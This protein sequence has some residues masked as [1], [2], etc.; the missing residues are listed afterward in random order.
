MADH[1]CRRV[2]EKCEALLKR[3]V[4][5]SLGIVRVGGRGND[6]A[7]ER[8]AVK[9][10]QSLSIFVKRFL[11]EENATGKELQRVLEEINADPDIHGCLVLRPLPPHLNE[12]E[13]SRILNP[14][15]DVDVITTASMGRMVTKTGNDFAP[16]TAAAC[17]ELLQYY[18]IPLQ[19][20]RVTVVG[21][22][23]NVGLSIA[24]LLLNEEAT[25]SICHIYTPPPE[26]IRL[27]SEAD[28]II[29]A[30]GRAGL[31]GA[32]HVRP[33]QIVID[34]GVNTTENGMIRGDTDF[35]S[36]EPIVKA[37][38][39][40][41]GGIGAITSCIL[42]EHVADAAIRQTGRPIIRRPPQSWRPPGR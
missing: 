9:R 26:V 29:S 25:V 4:V 7:Y 14:E 28:I 42:M 39:P 3:G 16:C 37:I 23:I 13:L 40:V 12:A 32:E 30:A 36:V 19:G 41:P 31:I 10:A 21:K 22:G 1:V 38:T 6:I 24:L 15:K 35:P 18:R 2:R 5:P 27:C 33:G 11:L 8:G 34:V 17:L 20:K